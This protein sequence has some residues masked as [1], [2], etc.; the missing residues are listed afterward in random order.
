MRMCGLCYSYISYSTHTPY[1]TQNTYD[2]C[3]YTN[4]HNVSTIRL[5]PYDNGLVYVFM[6]CHM[7]LHTI[8]NTRQCGVCACR[9]PNFKV[10]FG[11]CVRVLFVRRLPQS[12][13]NNNNNICTLIFFAVLSPLFVFTFGGFVCGVLRVCVF[14]GLFRVF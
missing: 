6:I 3:A 7:R 1:M 13:N 2:F 4:I 9:Y 10:K 12:T 11:A 8:V 5:T 14:A